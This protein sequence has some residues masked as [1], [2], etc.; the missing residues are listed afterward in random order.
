MQQLHAKCVKCIY[1]REEFS[2]CK[3]IHLL[4]EMYTEN[5]L[6]SSLLYTSSVGERDGSI[7]MEEVVQLSVEPSSPHQIF[8]LSFNNSNE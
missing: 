2:T 1:S 3:L 7:G 4:Q 5:I 6:Q 8:L